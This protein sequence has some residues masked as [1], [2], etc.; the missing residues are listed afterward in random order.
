M[1]RSTRHYSVASAAHALSEIVRTAAGMSGIFGARRSRLRIALSL[2]L[3]LPI[4]VLFVQEAS[5]SAQ[6]ALAAFAMGCLLR[7]G[8][9]FAS[10]G[11]RGIARRLKARLGAER[12]FAA[13][14]A[15]AALSL[16]VHRLGFAALL[17]APTGFAE[18]VPVDT[19]GAAVRAAG[20]L[21]LTLG[22]G[23]SV[24][25]TRRTGVDTYYYRDL[26]MGPEHVKL[27]CD[28]AYS[29]AG[30]PVYG[31]GQLAAYGAA[32]LA[33][34]PEGLMAAALNQ[35][36]LYAFNLRVE[37][38]HLRDAARILTEHEL[39]G[40]LARTLLE[41]ERGAQS[42][43]E[44]LQAERRSMPPPRR[45]RQTSHVEPTETAAAAEPAPVDGVRELRGVAAEPERPTPAELDSSDI[46]VV[47]DS[48]AA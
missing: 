32:L 8:F 27:E 3:L 17:F 33:L 25:A 45:R 13:Y 16:F 35:L 5:S 14:E 4:G 21:L 15:A 24:L 6:K 43:G 38:P 10:F 12:G 37:Q 47:P 18:L 26:F 20:A 29:F 30:N 39:R 41:P 7:H 2:V 11:P 23:V 31:V 48:R 28:G 44:R 46:D 40:S 22:V 42:L 36:A 9:L 34:S 19:A 1:A